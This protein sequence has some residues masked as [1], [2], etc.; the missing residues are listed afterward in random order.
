MPKNVFFPHIQ[1]MQRPVQYVSTL[2]QTSPR[3]FNSINQSWEL[4][5][6]HSWRMSEIPPLSSQACQSS[7][8]PF[9]QRRQIPSP[10]LFWTCHIPPPSLQRC[11]VPPSPISK[12]SWVSPAPTIQNC[13]IPSPLKKEEVIKSSYQ[14]THLCQFSGCQV[15]SHKLQSHQ[16]PFLK[17]A[18]IESTLSLEW[19]LSQVTQHILSRDYSSHNV[20]P[21]YPLCPYVS[22]CWVLTITNISS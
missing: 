8:P 7:L 1:E 12:K 16:D 19:L 11:Q 13:L 18:S 22:I 21:L 17:T 20:T 9:L 2:L 5:F 10:P 4:F 14:V 3:Q 15:L 6:R